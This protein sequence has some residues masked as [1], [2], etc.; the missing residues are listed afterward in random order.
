MIGVDDLKKVV[1]Q[2]RNDLTKKRKKLLR[3]I[4]RKM[5]SAANR[6]EESIFYSIN[7]NDY[8]FLKRYL[9]NLGYLVS[10]LNLPH[11]PCDNKIP[12]IRISWYSFERKDYGELPTGGMPIK[13]KEVKFVPCS[14]E[15]EEAISKYW[16]KN[17]RP[18]FRGN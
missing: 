17:A 16:D 18:K 5:I 11:A 12:V 9:E 13:S 6:G 14:K 2:Q 15:A 3:K 10:L 4:E 1:E 8:L 7:F